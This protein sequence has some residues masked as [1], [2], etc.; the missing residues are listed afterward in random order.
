[1]R[2]SSSEPSGSGPRPNARRRG[3]PRGVGTSRASSRG[4]SARTVPI[5]TATASDGGA[6][7]VDEPAARLARHPAPPGTA[8][9]PSSVT[10]TLY[11]TNGRPVDT[12]VRQASFCTRAS[13]RVD[14]LDLDA[15]LAQPLEAAGRLGVRVAHADDDPRDAG[16]ERASVHGGVVPQCAHGSSVT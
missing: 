14:E 2:S 13:Q 1:M 6:Q 16:A 8:T 5:P 12:H 4:A 3:W 11:V 10:A 9:R 7:L 15:R